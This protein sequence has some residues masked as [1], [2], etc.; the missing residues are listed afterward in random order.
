MENASKALIFAGGLLISMLI[1]AALIFTISQV[2]N[3]KSQEQ[4]AEQTDEVAEY[5]NKFN[6][7]ASENLFGVDLISLC[8]EVSNY[9]AK[10]SD[11]KY[12]HEIELIFNFS[13]SNP[14]GDYIKNGTYKYIKDN[15]PSS[16]NLLKQYQDFE[17]NFENLANTK[18]KDYT[19]KQIATMRTDEKENKFGNIPQQIEEKI[20][21]YNSLKAMFTEF[22][23]KKFKGEITK[24]DNTGRITQMTFTSK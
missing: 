22:K 16:N 9:N 18:F 10:E 19:I 11:N 5:N 15:S 17:N 21:D 24:Q 23:T 12:Y 14:L 2:R 6:K 1:V 3:L 8:N 13:G 4:Q 20:A 7:Y